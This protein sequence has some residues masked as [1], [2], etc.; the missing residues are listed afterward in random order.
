MVTLGLKTDK[1]SRRPH[2]F[3]PS[4][5]EGMRSLYPEEIEVLKKNGCRSRSETWDNVFVRP[6][7]FTPE[8]IHDTEFHGT[9]VIGMLRKAFLT[10]HDLQLNCGI[11]NSRLEN[12]I[13]GDDVCIRNL[14]Y[15]V[16]YKIGSRVIL[17]N[18]QEMSCTSRSKFGS[19][20]LKKGEDEDVRIAIGVANENNGRS[21]LPF[22]T[23]ICA[24]AY[25]W[26][27]Y[28]ED[29]P[30]MK[31]FYELTE[32]DNDKN[33]PAYGIVG[34][35][36][37]IKNTVS[38]KDAAIGSHAYIKGALKLKN[39][40]VCSSEAE[41]SQIGE[42]V[43]M[44]NGIMGYGSKV[45]YQAVAVR[46]VIGR[47][48]QLKYGAR[49]LN[50]VLGDNSTVSCCELLN[51]LIFPFHEQHHNT[52]FLIAATLLGQSNIA[53]GATIGSNH[54]SRSADGEIIA[55][56]GFWPGLSSDFK[57]NSKFASFTLISKGS[58]Q[59]ELNIT[60]PFSLVSIDS[61]EQAIHIIPA[62]WFMYNMYALIRNSLKF[63]ERDKRAVKTQHIETDPFAP[64]TISEILSAL[65]RLIE[66]TG[67]ALKLRS[68]QQ[69][70]DFLHQNPDSELVLEDPQAQRR[71]GSKILKPVQAYR[72]Y[73]KIAKYFAARSLLELCE[74]KE[75]DALDAAALHT[76]TETALYTEWVNAGGQII[77]EAKLFELFDM[78]KSH[79][80]NTWDEVHDFYSRCQNSYVLYKAR[81]ALFVLE[82][83]Y[84]RP[85]ADFS[86]EIYA[87]I[88]ADVIAVAD[89][90]YEGFRSSRQ[91]DYTD[92]FRTM[93][94][95]NK[96]EMSAVLGDAES[97]NL[98]PRMEA[99]TA[100]FKRKIAL[101]FSALTDSLDR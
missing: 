20:L 36:T 22:E 61:T 72:E 48:C 50:S 60:Y 47:N 14:P 87:D 9:V 90:I 40:R 2:Y 27:R 76:L 85:L 24:D 101:L 79:T 54:N 70:K 80:I 62:Y 12:C 6:E 26:S 95:R 82:Y 91:K 96:D 69:A 1:E 18:V 15:L 99:E 37:V 89:N 74:K 35:D 10:Y 33:K 66:L 67:R 23:M 34:N 5:F 32:Y 21:V 52:S 11:Y 77:P 100:A 78:I 73:R 57:H 25:I 16:N 43:E 41:P 42:G 44:V 68:R 63:K 97:N 94:Y 98:F 38:I 7:A 30:L 8:L 75:K 88:C 4:F 49:L 86:S 3:E 64:D 46:F 55:G 65:D 58:Y 29:E 93:V 31:R 28:R 45:F 19:G 84:A 56:R 81:Y 83:L 13:I 59:N 51:N 92:F 39:I 53:A 71:F 17:F